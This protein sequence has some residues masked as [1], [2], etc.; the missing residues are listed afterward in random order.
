[1][2]RAT[3]YDVLGAAFVPVVFFSIWLA[4]H[5][6]SATNKPACIE[7]MPEDRESDNGTL[8]EPEDPCP[9]E[10]MCDPGVSYVGSANYGRLS[11]INLEN[12]GKLQVA[13]TLS[14]TEG[15]GGAIPL[16]I[17]DT[18]YVRSRFNTVAV[19]LRDQ[20]VRW[21]Y[22]LKWGG[23]VAP[24]V[25]CETVSRS[26]AYGDG[27]IFLQSGNSLLALDAKAG[28]VVW[29]V[30]GEG[31]S[32]HVI[33]GKVLMYSPG[34]QG[35]DRGHLIAYDAQG[36]KR[37]WTAWDAG[38]D[39]DRRFDSRTMS[40][41]N[42]LLAQA[43]GDFGARRDQVN[44]FEPIKGTIWGGY[45]Y[46]GRLKVVYYSIGRPGSLVPGQARG[47]YGSSMAIFARDLDTGVAKWTFQLAPHD[48]WD[49]GNTDDLLLINLLNHGKSI[50]ALVHF[51][52][53][54]FAYSFDRETGAL[55]RAE[56]FDPAMQWATV[57]DMKS[58]RPVFD[59]AYD[60]RTNTANVNGA[61]A[62]ADGFTSRE[63]HS[64]S[65]DRRL[66]LVVFPTGHR[67]AA[68]VA[69]GEPT[70][71]LI[72]WDPTAGNIAWSNHDR[73]SA[74]SSAL[75]TAG[76]LVFYVALD[77]Y[78]KAVGN[79]DGKEHWRFKIS[80][81]AAGSPFTYQYNGKQFLGLLSGTE[82]SHGI[83][84]ISGTGESAPN[85][86]MDPSRSSPNPL[87]GTLYV[88]STSE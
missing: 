59:R 60:S 83:A 44:Q 10:G 46:D 50:A 3:S 9:K 14:G 72:A 80:S 62:C 27:K 75:T 31:G 22:E 77:G 23:D 13:W 15:G 37:L 88:F 47:D 78:L 19:N 57:V 84:R 7:R 58:G 38:P 16:V 12:V 87:D 55:L 64:A 6:S 39:S 66:G 28:K 74:C 30:P 4:P 40:W 85:S 73:I 51:D 86:R 33:A 63:H 17:G 54:G 69:T 2:F 67:A 43:G 82:R 61:A 49:F 81:A 68:T 70:G 36:G 32:P 29:E 71:D 8:C 79:N 21:K 45:A 1:M 53:N 34:H 35:G 52:R 18:M 65:Y 76:G 26:L 56:R 11:Q 20:T 24:M 25:C 42:G 48:A 41:S 5:T